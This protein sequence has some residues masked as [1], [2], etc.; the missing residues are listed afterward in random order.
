MSKEFDEFDEFSGTNAQDD[1]EFRQEGGDNSA[2]GL[3]ELENFEAELAAAEVDDDAQLQGL[4]YENFV[5][6]KKQELLKF[7][8]AVEPWGKI[9]VDQYGKSARIRS[10]SKDQVEFSYVNGQV[11]VTTLITNRSGKEIPTYYIQIST[12]KRIVTETYSSLVLVHENNELNMAI[13]DQILYIETVTLK[14]EEYKQ[15]ETPDK[16]T[17]VD[18][19]VLQLLT[20]KL[21]FVLAATDRVAEKVINFKEDKAYISTAVFAAAV[22]NPFEFD[23][24]SISKICM[25]LLGILTEASKLTFNCALISGE[26]KERL[27]LCEVDG[28][29]KV[30]LPVFDLN[31]TLVERAKEVTEFSGTMEVSNEALSKLVDLSKS[32]EYLS[33]VLEFQVSKDALNVTIRSK[34]LARKI[35]YSFPF[36]GSPEASDEVVRV[37]AAIVKPYL[38]LGANSTSH[39][40]TKAGWG[41]QTDWGNI[42]IRKTV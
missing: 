21:S 34:D 40:F 22:R 7:L 17:K 38:H 3:S 24:M 14:D 5:I 31:K 12:L 1:P 2:D 42:L 18:V 29:W 26:G 8:R 13:L 41:L 23:D 10:I 27:L 11:Q 4:D 19:E 28:L 9:A 33:E 35:P 6:L 15:V 37:S 16:L 39:A 20:K 25:D 36:T 30:T 32:L